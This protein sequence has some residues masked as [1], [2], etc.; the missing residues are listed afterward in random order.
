VA[1]GTTS[2][3]L[4]RM[5]DARII[6]YGGMLGEGTLAVLATMAVAAGLPDW[7]THYHSWNASGIVAISNFVVGAGRFLEALGLHLGWAQAVV[8]LLAIAFAA[9]SMDTGAR[10]QR[11]VVMELG[12]ALKIKPLRNRYVA[13]VLAVGPAIPLVL[14]GPRVWAPLWLLFGTTNQLIG[15][16]TLLVLFVYLFRS[17]RPLLHFALPMIFLVVMTT[18]A[19]VYNLVKWTQALGTDQATAS[20]LTIVIG[21]VILVL[22]LWMIT[23]AAILVFKLRAERREAAP[24]G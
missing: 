9:T 12:G 20:G 16:M 1:S 3:Q 2:K 21:A 11:L 15:G 24:A 18:S 10:I 5:A 19:M 8:A 23:E 4:D 14:A 22:E 7:G 17:R 13:T 6:G